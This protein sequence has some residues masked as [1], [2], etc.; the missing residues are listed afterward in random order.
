MN[1]ATLPGGG[2]GGDTCMISRTGPASYERMASF[3]LIW[4]LPFVFIGIY[5]LIRRRA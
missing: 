5:R 4:L 3:F 1:G 2:G